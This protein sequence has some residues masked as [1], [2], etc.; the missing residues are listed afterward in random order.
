MTEYGIMLEKSLIYTALTR[1]KK[2]AVFIGQRHAL[3]KAVKTINKAKRQT[4]LSE[5]L[6]FE[7]NLVE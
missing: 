3:M 4:S 2:L 1:A 6:I 7:K 5:L